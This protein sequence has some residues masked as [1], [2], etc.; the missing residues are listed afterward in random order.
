MLPAGGALAAGAGRDDHGNAARDEPRGGAETAGEASA[1]EA[2]IAEAVDMLRAYP[3]ADVEGVKAENT[4][5]PQTRQQ[6]E[7]PAK[8]KAG[9]RWGLR[10]LGARVRTQLRRPPRP[11][12][13]RR[14]AS[15]RAIVVRV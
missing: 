2:K 8:Q 11:S 5:E 9:A 4:V 15:S 12:R 3:M 14:R 6:E 13:Q 1:L 7:K 10:A